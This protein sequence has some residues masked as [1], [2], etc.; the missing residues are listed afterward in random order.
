MLHLGHAWGLSGMHHCL[1]IC[2]FAG[3]LSFALAAEPTSPHIIVLAI[4]GLRADHLSCMGQSISQTPNLDQLAS[5]G[6]L[7]ESAYATTT[8]DVA[9]FTDLIY[10]AN[11]PLSTIVHA[12]GDFPLLLRNRGYTVDFIGQ[13]P[14]ASG[15]ESALAFE[16]S[17]SHWFGVHHDEDLLE[18]LASPNTPESDIAQVIVNTVRQRLLILPPTQPWCLTIT[19]PLSML[20]NDDLQVN[21]RPPARQYN[22]PLPPNYIPPSE[23]PA[24]TQATDHLTPTVVRQQL[25]TVYQA[26]ERFDVLIGAL[27][28]DITT[29]GQMDNTV[30]IIT[31]ARGVL[32]GEH[33]L[34]GTNSVYTPVV[35]IPCIIV[36]PRQPT[37]RR[38]WREQRL[39]T[40]NDIAPTV[41]GYAQVAKPT[42]MTGRNLAPLIHGLS[43]LWRDHVLSKH[44]DKT[45]SCQS[46]RDGDWAYFRWSTEHV[47]VREELYHIRVDPY[48]QRNVI[49]DV[50]YVEV[51]NRLV[52]ALNKLSKITP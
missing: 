45:T 44:H 16:R 22:L 3:S 39:T 41:L 24:T 40:T 33:G 20:H 4:D 17:F 50:A 21:A 43:V 37:N 30:F 18:R 35:H 52:E 46:V 34:S 7:F 19:L 38:G 48:E 28:D 6:V 49:A 8:D 51:L 10:G 11:Q 9:N 12:N 47:V 36:D 2:L 31:G 42:S 15:S 14:L 1:V 32:I 27:R 5:T 23:L 29:A 26:V 25:M 13:T